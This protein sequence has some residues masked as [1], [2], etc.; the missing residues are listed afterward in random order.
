MAKNQRLVFGINSLIVFY[1]CALYYFY[2]MT[3]VT[4]N[5]K[6]KDYQTVLLEGLK[7]DFQLFGEVLSA[8]KD[9]GKATFKE[10][11]KLKEDMEEAKGELRLIR[12]ELKEKVSVL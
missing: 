2:N 1:Q 5:R 11:G 3:K 8:V 12:H 6:P 10:V 7:S 4:E 9:K